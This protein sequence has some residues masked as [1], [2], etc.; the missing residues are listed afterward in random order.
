[1]S[2][3][4][5]TMPNLCKSL[6]ENGKECVE[7]SPK[8]AY[9]VL[10]SSR[11]LVV[12]S[13]QSIP[14]THIGYWKTQTTKNASTGVDLVTPTA[15]RMMLKDMRKPL[16]ILAQSQTRECTTWSENR[17]ILPTHSTHQG[18]RR[19]RAAGVSKGERKR[20]QPHDQ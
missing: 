11:E 6:Q 15:S 9:L 19:G 14:R 7:L 10:Q 20:R 16:K 18:T 1:M 2:R 13:S 4:Q 5:R 12:P 8:L 17:M 3:N